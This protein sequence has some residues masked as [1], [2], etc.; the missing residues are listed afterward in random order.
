MKRTDLL[1]QPLAPFQLADVASAVRLIVLKFMARVAEGNP[2]VQLETKVR[3]LGE[4]QDMVCSEVPALRV[5]T[6]PASETI[7]GKYRVSPRLVF[8]LAAIISTA[9]RRATSPSV[10]E[11]SARRAR[12]QDRADSRSGRR[13]AGDAFSRRR[14]SLPGRAHASFGFIGVCFTLECA[15]SPFGGFALLHL[16]TG[17][18]RSVMAIVTAHIPAEVDERLPL[19]ASGASLQPCGDLRFVF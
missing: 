8:R 3:V 5:L 9:G 1:P 14:L 2:I 19:L 18:A 6:F 13:R 7:A 11:R 17:K 15:G 12:S 4:R 10:M 16:A